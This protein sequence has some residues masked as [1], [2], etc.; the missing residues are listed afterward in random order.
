M[1]DHLGNPE[2]SLQGVANWAFQ[3]SSGGFGVYLLAVMQQQAWWILSQSEFLAEW[4][5][6]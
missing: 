1:G 4:H 3:S 2:G 5:F 6:P